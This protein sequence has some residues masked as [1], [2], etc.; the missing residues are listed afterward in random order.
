MRA[1]ICSV[2]SVPRTA[3]TPPSPYLPGCYGPPTACYN[4]F[5]CWTKAG[6]CNQITDAITEAHD[7]D[8]QMIDGTSMRVHHSAATLEIATRIKA[9]NRALKSEKELLLERLNQ[10]LRK[11]LTKIRHR[12]TKQK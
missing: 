4:H 3:A 6:I 8:F 2:P 5:R 7:G 10:P 11:G 9:A 12:L 1:S